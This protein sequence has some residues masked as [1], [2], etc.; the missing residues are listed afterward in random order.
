MAENMSADVLKNNLTNP[1]K[2][3]LWSVLIPAVVGGG[4]EKALETRCQST[5]LPGR[6]VGA[7]IIPY[8]GTPGL[9]Y[10]GK[11]NM[12]HV[13]NTTFIE[14]ASDTKTFNTLYAWHQAIVNAKTGV[15]GPDII[16]K[17]DLYLKCEDQLGN[18]WL[19]IKMIGAYP[20]DMGSI[21]L[22]YASQEQISFPVRWA[23]DRWE[24]V[25]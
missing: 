22:N 19:T 20:Q 10:P 5:A 3:F 17:K 9:V 8:K 2:A 23:Y 18:V 16:L 15:G 12:D 7:I 11:L 4:D 14:S 6:S 25:D 13:W 24:K 1:A 21:P